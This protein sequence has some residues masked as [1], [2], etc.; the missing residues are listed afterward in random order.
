[1]ISE[2]IDEFHSSSRI[3]VA[4]FRGDGKYSKPYAKWQELGCPVKPD[5]R[6]MSELV[7]SGELQVYGSP[8]W[9]TAK[10]GKL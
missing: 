1:M 7:K 2:L 6:Q 4:P 9:M 10:D 5:S 8:Q 3:L